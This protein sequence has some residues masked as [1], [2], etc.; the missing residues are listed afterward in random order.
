MGYLQFTIACLV[1]LTQKFIKSFCLKE[2]M[3]KCEK[4]VKKGVSSNSVFVYFDQT[5]GCNFIQGNV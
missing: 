5:H 1:A 4:I 2:G 3:H